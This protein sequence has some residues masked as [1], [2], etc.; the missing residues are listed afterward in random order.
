LNSY[1]NELR[2]AKLSTYQTINLKLKK[3]EERGN[4]TK[5]KNT[6][7]YQYIKYMTHYSLT[8]QQITIYLQLYL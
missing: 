2:L 8:L 5:T 4:S 3:K 1:D 7:A 6:I